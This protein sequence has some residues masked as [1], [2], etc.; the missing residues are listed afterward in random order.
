[1]SNLTASRNIVRYADQALA[2]FEPPIYLKNGETI[3]GGS[4]IFVDTSTGYAYASTGA[5]RVC[6]GYNDGS[7][8]GPATSD[9]SHSIV[10]RRGPVALANSG[11]SALANID[12]GA[13][14]FAEDN[15]TAR[16]VNTGSAYAPLGT[17]IG[18]DGSA[19]VVDVG[20]S[21]LV[22]LSSYQPLDADLTALAALDATAG[23]L[24]KTAAN[25]YARRTLTGPAAGI[26]V[27]NGDGQ[28]GNPT[29]ALAN[30]LAALEALDATAGILVKT[31]AEAYAR[32]SVSVG[33]S[34]LTVANADGSAGNPSVDGSVALKA[35]SA[36]AGTGFIAQTGGAADNGTFAER[37]L[38]SS[39]SSLS[40]TNP[41]GVAGNPDIKNLFAPIEVADPGT[42]VAIPVTG[43]ATVNFTVGAGAETNTLAIPTFVGQRMVLNCG[44]IG[45]GTRAVTAASAINAAG[46]TVMTFNAARDN[47]ELRAVKVGGVL[48]WEIGFNASVALS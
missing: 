3:Y 38:T 14:V 48:A 19:V 25:T 23:I 13:L 46:N 8:V 11:T 1:M 6:I 39:D 42:G 4:L 5:T 35:I 2:V 34:A 44:S 21:P 45:G 47:C 9:S 18:L 26:T 36:F 41:A 20:S 31:G 33:S 43:S 24:A 32:R 37:S 17:F 10:P 28:A 12:R 27:S 7:D 15:Q 22:T 29:L 30:D 40:I 16:K